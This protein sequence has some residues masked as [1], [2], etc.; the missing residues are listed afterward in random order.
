MTLPVRGDA[1]CSAD[2]N[3]VYCNGAG[4]DAIRI[5]TPT[6]QVRWKLPSAASG[7]APAPRV[8]P[9][10]VRKDMVFAVRSRGPGAAP[11]ANV[12]ALDRR[13]GKQVWKQE[14]ADEATGARTAKPGFD[15]LYAQTEQYPAM[16]G[17]DLKTGRY[18]WSTDYPADPGQECTPVSSIYKPSFL[19]PPAPGDTSDT[20]RLI[21]VDPQSNQPYPLATLPRST[22]F[23]G[24]RGA[25]LYFAAYRPEDIGKP[26]KRYHRVDIV[27]PLPPGDMPEN[28][29]PA[30]SH[31]F[32]ETA[33][34]QPSFHDYSGTIAFPGPDG[35]VTAVRAAGGTR[36]WT[37]RP[38]SDM[39]AGSWGRRTP[40]VVMT[41]LGTYILTPDAELFAV[42]PANG[43]PLS[44]RKLALPDPRAVA[45]AQ[46]Q[47]MD[48]G[49]GLVGR[50]GNQLVS[51]EHRI[52]ERGM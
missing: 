5:W 15:T 32:P 22:E 13:T 52:E 2:G 25:K 34:R 29:Q 24:S 38:P 42:D 44:R 40:A 9:L 18:L 8:A 11:G 3:S 31:P 19:C 10:G 4:Y 26:V 6:G 28:L 48:A 17:F 7:K 39:D 33:A 36:L 50:F 35:S 47:L 23:L 41:M 21:G 12:A 27:N 1:L 45:G 49:P 20:L 51:V 16:G 46:P 30:R 14:L 37:F 43:T